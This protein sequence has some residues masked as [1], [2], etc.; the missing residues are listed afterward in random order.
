MAGIEGTGSAAQSAANV[1]S[2]LATNAIREQNQ[3]ERQV[4]S[5]LEK[6][7]DTNE[8]QKRETREIPGLGRAVDISV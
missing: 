6:A 4:A 8:Q 3:Q 1:R 5:L 7:Q 2:E